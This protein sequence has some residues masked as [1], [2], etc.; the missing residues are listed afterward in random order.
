MRFAVPTEQLIV[1]LLAVP[2]VAAIVL[3]SV[4]LARRRRAREAFA[5]AHLME[6]LAPGA[7]LARGR[8]RATL[9]VIG[10]V[11]LG[12]AA[13]RPQV[14]TRM[15]VAKRTGVDLMLAIDV[16]E[17]MRARDLKPD[18]LEKARRE[19]FSLIQLLDGD[20]VGIITFSGSAFVQ[21]PLTLDYG[22]A[23]M[24]LSAVETGT[25]PR[26]GTALGEAISAGVR[27]LSTQPDRAKVLVIM[28]DG[29]DHGS[30]PLVAATEAAEAGVV[31]YTIGLGSTSGEPIPLEAGAGAGYKRDRQGQIIMSRLDESTLIDVAAVTGGRYFRATDN[32]RELAAIE[33]AIS[34]MQQGELESKMM[35]YYEER[36]Q[37]PLAVSLGFV[38]LGSLLPERTRRRHGEV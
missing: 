21:C 18:R 25:I 36:F 10:V 35:A 31:I 13:G 17:S 14:G 5:E 9:V 4:A 37:L 12:L 26:P 23:T 28:T 3:S 24:L 33:E 22:A 2:V 38:L 15:G 8:A 11:F 19:A 34:R 32:E 30:E 29:E 20:R 7:S 6:R 1:W 16:S 27:S